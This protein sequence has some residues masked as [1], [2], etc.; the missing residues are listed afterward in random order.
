MALP[1]LRLHGR[2]GSSPHESRGRLGD[3]AEEE[4]DHVVLELPPESSRSISYMRRTF[5]YPRWPLRPKQAIENRRELAIK[6]IES[7]VA[8][9]AGA[10]FVSHC[11]PQS[12]V[13]QEPT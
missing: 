11:S 7:K 6:T 2:T 9:H 12:F 10:G 5:L 8:K 4:P 1:V 3:D 13:G